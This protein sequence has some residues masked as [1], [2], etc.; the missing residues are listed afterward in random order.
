MDSNY[1]K[2]LAYS[3][4]VDVCGIG[5][6]DRFKDA[7]KGFHPLDIY[8][9]AKS[10][11][12]IGKHF[13]ASLFDANTKAPYTFV[14][15]K[16]FQ[17]LDDISIKLAFYI[18]SQGYKAIP[19]PSDE[20]YEYWDSENKHGRGILSLKHAA[21]ACGI[22][23]IGKNTLLINEKYGNRLYFGAVITNIELTADALARNL[24]T[25]SCNICLK[26]CPQ[27]ALDGI[28]INQKRCRQVCATSTPGGGTIY[29]C[30]TCRKICP[31]S[32]V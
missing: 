18:E 26:A 5:G 4:D 19:I 31:F 1:I 9:E 8:S 7:P 17:M 14:K 25:E 23:C 30:Y 11:I 27:S 20:P 3:F 24:C 28:T 22:G 10:V 21:Q 15:N 32:K 6:V 2:K 16:I 29:S 12:S 13:S